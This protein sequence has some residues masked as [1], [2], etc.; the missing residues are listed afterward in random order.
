[1]IPQ[2]INKHHNTRH[3]SSPIQTPILPTKKSRLLLSGFFFFGKKLIQ[4]N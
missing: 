4:V 3:L 2:R 1:M